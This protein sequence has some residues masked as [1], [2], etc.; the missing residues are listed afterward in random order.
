MTLPINSSLHK[1]STNSTNNT[2]QNDHFTEKIVSSSHVLPNVGKVRS[3]ESLETISRSRTTSKISVPPL[4][5][6]IFRASKSLDGKGLFSIWLLC[7]CEYAL[8]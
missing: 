4:R 5:D 1:N 2:V 7:D 3:T 6:S 8:F